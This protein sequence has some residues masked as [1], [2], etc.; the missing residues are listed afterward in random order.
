[1]IDILQ[2]LSSKGKRFRFKGFIFA[3]TGIR[4]DLFIKGLHAVTSNK[5]YIDYSNYQGYKKRL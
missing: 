5:N 1:M 4:S 3:S 2:H